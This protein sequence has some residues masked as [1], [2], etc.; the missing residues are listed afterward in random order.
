SNVG[1]RF[2]INQHFTLGRR[3][4]SRNRFQNRRLA[5]ARWSQEDDNLTGVRFVVNIERNIA[6]RLSAATF[7]ID[8]SHAQIRHAQLWR[9]TTLIS[10]IRNVR[11][12]PGRANVYSNCAGLA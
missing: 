10:M 2:A 6:H 9:S 11:L 12:T 4:E 7:A 5:A 3:Q 1:Y 8:V